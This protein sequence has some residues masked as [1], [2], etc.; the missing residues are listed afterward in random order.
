MGGV[1]YRPT[2]AAVSVFE[3]RKREIEVAR[4]DFDRLM[5]E[6][7]AFNKAN[8]RKIAPITDKPPAVTAQ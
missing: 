1:A 6:V 7:D 4:R 8:A 5:Q 2:D 3:D